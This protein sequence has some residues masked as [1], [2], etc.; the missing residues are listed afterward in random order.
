MKSY[1]VAQAGLK[2]MT[3]LNTRNFKKILRVYKERGGVG[4]KYKELGIRWHQ[5]AVGVMESRK[6]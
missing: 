5:S 6:Q 1:Y 2:T 3:F 4:Q